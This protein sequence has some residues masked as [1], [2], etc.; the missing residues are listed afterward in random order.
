MLKAETIDKKMKDKAKKEAKNKPKVEAKKELKITGK[1]VALRTF[2]TPRVC[3]VAGSSYTIGRD[4]D[5][6]QA[7]SWLKSGFIEKVAD[8]PAP[9]ETK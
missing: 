9:S 2:G 1:V 5:E 6:D 8:S 3:Y 4:L 7:R